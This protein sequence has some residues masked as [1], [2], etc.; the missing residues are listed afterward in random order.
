MPNLN[1]SRAQVSLFDIYSYFSLINRKQGGGP[2]IEEQ[3]HNLSLIQHQILNQLPASV[4]HIKLTPSLATAVKDVRYK[5]LLEALNLDSPKFQ[6]GISEEEGEFAGFHFMWVWGSKL[7]SE[8]YEPFC[9]AFCDPNLSRVAVCVSEGQR[10]MGKLLYTTPLW[11]LRK[12]DEEKRKVGSVLF[13]G[14]ISGRTDIVVMDYDPGSDILRHNV[15]FAIE[16]K[17]NKDI[18]TPAK[19][20]SALREATT[21]LLGL[22]GDNSINTPPVLLTDFCSVFIVLQLH[23]KSNYPL[24]FEILAWRCSSNKS[25]LHKALTASMLPCVSA[26]FGRPDTPSGSDGD[27]DEEIAGLQVTGDEDTEDDNKENA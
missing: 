2:S 18:N 25:A 3:I 16:V 26:D 15:K 21:Q 4:V 23:L 8:S 5:K 17:R 9:E 19:L 1:T 10:L 14:E 12:V 22:C 7:E 24:K 13:R 11:S 27:P 20:K 6:E